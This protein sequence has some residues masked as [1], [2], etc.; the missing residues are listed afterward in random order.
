MNSKTFFCALALAIASTTAFAQVDSFKMYPQARANPSPMC[1]VFTSLTLTPNS[2]GVTANL[3]NGV[4]GV[5]TIVVAPN[6]RSYS[7]TLQGDDGCGSTIYTGHNV[8]L[9]D[10]RA[11]RCEDVI[12]ALIVFKEGNQTLFS[13]P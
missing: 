8:K 11:R 1:D 2:N 4:S 13:N 9:T 3:V 6:E 7:L 5:C 10:N 12:P